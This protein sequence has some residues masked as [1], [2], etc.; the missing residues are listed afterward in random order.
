MADPVKRGLIGH[1]LPPSSRPSRPGGG[2]HRPRR[3]STASPAWVRTLPPPPP[4]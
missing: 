2:S 1:A 3:G 4:A